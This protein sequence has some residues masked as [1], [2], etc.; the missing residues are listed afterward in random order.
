MLPPRQLKLPRSISSGGGAAR[1]RKRHS[2]KSAVVVLPAECNL[3]QHP[4]SS[5]DGVSIPHL[6]LEKEGECMFKKYKNLAF[7]KKLKKMQR[8]QTRAIRIAIAMKDSFKCRF[9]D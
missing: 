5:I 1:R 2:N 3:T 8:I 9:I 4:V 6:E 7:E